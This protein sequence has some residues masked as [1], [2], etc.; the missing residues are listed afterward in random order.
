MKTQMAL[1]RTLDAW[2]KQLD[3]VRLPIPAESHERVRRA[4]GDSRRSMR[5]I[6]DLIQDSPA[7]ALSIMRE[8]NRSG[9]SSTARRKAS[10]WPLPALA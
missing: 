7:L 2:I 1:P 9:S 6:A 8:A 10:K 5:E 3:G 4:L